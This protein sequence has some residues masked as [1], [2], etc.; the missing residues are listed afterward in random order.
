MKKYLLQIGLG[1]F[2]LLVM[3]APAFGWGFLSPA[4]ERP[5]LYSLSVLIVSNS[6]Q[7]P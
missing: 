1:F 4:Q 5:V 2:A 7:R 3:T 6:S